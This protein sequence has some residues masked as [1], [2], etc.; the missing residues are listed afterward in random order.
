MQVL[1]TGANGFLGSAL[2]KELIKQNYNVILLV[3]KSA[4]LWRLQEVLHLIKIYYYGDVIFEKIDSI[5]HMAW[6]GVENR[7][8]NLSFL[9]ENLSVAKHICELAKASGV[10]KI[11]ALGSQAEYGPQNKIL[12]ETDPLTP[13][14]VYGKEKD[15]IRQYFKK[16]CAQAEIEFTWIR[17]FSTYG[18]GD[19]PSWLIPSVVES[20]LQNMPPKLTRGEQK[21]DYLFSQDAV[22]ALIALMHAKGGIY[23]LGSGKC[24]TIRFVIEHIYNKIQPSCDLQFGQ[25]P[26]AEDQ[27]FF[28]QANIS[29]IQKETR[30]K[31]LTSLQEGLDMLIAYHIAQRKSILLNQ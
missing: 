17:V 6:Q 12:S 19:N 7:F 18:P 8:R 23:N 27:I 3:R 5:Y 29:K 10:K 14:T 4:D 15:I 13:T 28:L 30:W 26:Y 31:P 11:L 2:V 21:W 22:K 1:I 16:F 20:F 24:V 25:K 9:Q